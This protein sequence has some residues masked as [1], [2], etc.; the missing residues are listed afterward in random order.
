MKY[1]V[2]VN[3]GET[4]EWKLTKAGWEMDGRAVEADVQRI[5]D[6]RYHVLLGAHSCM[7][8]LIK[9]EDKTVEVLVNGKKHQVVLRD[10]G[11]TQRFFETREFF[12]MTANALC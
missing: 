4:R 1:K 9:R 5:G 7:V 6:H 2:N 12:L 8:E 10:S 3:G 11:F